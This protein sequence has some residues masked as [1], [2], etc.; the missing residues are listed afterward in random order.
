VHGIF[1]LDHILGLAD[2]IL[3]QFSYLAYA[4]GDNK[5]G[6]SDV[7]GIYI[8]PGL[9]VVIAQ[10]GTGKS[11]AITNLLKGAA[12][13]GVRVS[14][15]VW[16]EREAYSASGEPKH[17]VG[18]IDATIK[19]QKP[20]ILTIDS[21]RE[22]AQ[23]GS[24]PGRGGVNTTFYMH[25]TQWHHAFMDRGV[26]AFLVINPNTVTAEFVDAVIEICRGS[27]AGIL[28]LDGPGRGR[29]EH[30]ASGRQQKSIKIND[31]P[32]PVTKVLGDKELVR[33]TTAVNLEVADPGA[34]LNAKLEHVTSN[35]LSML[36]NG[37]K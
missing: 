27:L 2:P 35:Y 22:W 28:V 9:T 32:Y 14:A 37:A 16:N 11:T 36:T 7:N 33:T 34:K 29:Y 12:Q 20:Q 19:E 23:G 17:L 30:T 31:I 6:Q 1:A 3:P 5:E 21:A 25:L 10:S 13:A 15:I 4:D 8:E 26:A 24:A 18:L